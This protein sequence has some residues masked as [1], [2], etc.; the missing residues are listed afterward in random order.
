[1]Y[2]INSCV[3][4]YSG[5]YGNEDDGYTPIPYI[6]NQ[7]NIKVFPRKRDAEDTLKYLKRKLN[8]YDLWNFRI[9]KLNEMEDKGLMLSI[10]NDN[11]KEKYWKKVFKPLNNQEVEITNINV[12]NNVC[13]ISYLMLYCISSEEYIFSADT[14]KETVIDGF[15]NAIETRANE[16][17]IMI[18]ECGNIRNLF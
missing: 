17:I 2:V 1:M 8:V 5:F 16:M 9:I 4:L 18:R 7:K 13:T 14:D 15:C 10:K 3:G 6:E 12:V 11:K